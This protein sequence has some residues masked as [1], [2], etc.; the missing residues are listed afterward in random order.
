MS[1][2][3]LSPEE[4]FVLSCSA[5][6]IAELQAL[7]LS[8]RTAFSE[9]L[10]A[11][12]FSKV[13]HRIK[14]EARLK[15][16]GS[17]ADS[18]TAPATPTIDN[19]TGSAAVS[20]PQGKADPPT[21][22]PCCPPPAA[23]CCPHD[24]PASEPVP[25][26]ESIK[27]AAFA[28]AAT[29]TGARKFCVFKMGP[30]GLGYYRDSAKL[31]VHL[32]PAE[33]KLQRKHLGN[34]SW[35]SEEAEAETAIATATTSAAGLTTELT[36]APAA[37]PA[38]VPSPSSTALV[39]TSALFPPKKP[40][41]LSDK[42][43]A[44]LQHQSGPYDPPMR[45]GKYADTDYV[46]KI[47]SGNARGKWGIV[48]SC[49]MNQ[50]VVRTL[51]GAS[52]DASHYTDMMTTDMKL[53]R[54]LRCKK[55]WDARAPLARRTLHDDGKAQVH[56]SWT[57]NLGSSNLRLT[58][59]S[60]TAPKPGSGMGYYYAAITSDQRTMPVAEPLRIDSNEVTTAN[61]PA[62]ATGV[63]AKSEYYY[64]HRRKSEL[65]LT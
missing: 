2:R 51:N 3:S 18:T 48:M 24:Q 61:A 58:D 30:K 31:D 16:F 55:E 57:P 39:A 10:K 28:A 5:A 12:G 45:E 33:A 53:D 23:P 42:R 19:A 27:V 60:A 59:R 14:V 7:Q 47:T 29:F 13:G 17:A 37:A 62:A 54:F 49:K 38:A 22:A 65:R 26:T 15:Q 32:D 25:A 50:F 40:G 34:L 1:G 11:A 20:A 36:A 44:V 56:S 41:K 35:L 63:G 46:V 64:A 9:R 43:R 4:S 21:A 8:D 6:E 52:T